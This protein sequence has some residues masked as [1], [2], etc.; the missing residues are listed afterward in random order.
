M[1]KILSIFVFLFIF[2]ISGCF[3]S[4]YHVEQNATP[5]NTSNEKETPKPTAKPTPTLEPTS[6][7]TSKQ[8]STPKPTATSTPT[9]A[10]SISDVEIYF[11]KETITL[12][13][14]EDIQ[15]VYFCT[16]L[17]GY[18]GEIEPPVGNSY[19][20]GDVN[21]EVGEAEIDSD[22]DG[23][24]IPLIFSG[25]E[26]GTIKIEY[27]FTGNNNK[28]VLE[29]VVDIPVPE[30]I[31]YED[32]F[33]KICFIEVGKQGVEFLVEN[34]TDYVLT[35]QAD[36]VALNGYSTNDIVMSDDVAPRSK[37]K[38]VA[39]CDDFEEGLM[40][41]KISGQLRVI[42]FSYELLKKSYDAKFID[43]EVE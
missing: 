40:V 33:L 16:K 21:L 11:D 5:T 32:E 19:G 29:I 8:T 12:T 6:T 23:W 28:A 13:S 1:K 31:I 43:I 14:K 17:N 20:T 2:C 36:A 37:G 10:P 42:D 7:P 4:G 18:R 3:F 27:L 22:F 38:V 15:T 35:I 41:K 9:P 30:N 24:K 26:N 25:I 34:K 39:K